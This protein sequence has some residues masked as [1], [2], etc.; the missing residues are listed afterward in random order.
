MYHG[1]TPEITMADLHRIFSIK[2]NKGTE[3]QC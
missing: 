1:I 2:R 3:D